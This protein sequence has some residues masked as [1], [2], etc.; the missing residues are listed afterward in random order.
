M[1]FKLLTPLEYYERIWKSTTK[2]IVI[3]VTNAW[4]SNAWV[5]DAWVSDA[6]VPKAIWPSITPV[7]LS[8]FFWLLIFFLVCKFL[9]PPPWV[10]SKR[11]SPKRV[12]QRI[13]TKAKGIAVTISWPMSGSVRF[14]KLYL[15]VIW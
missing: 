7:T 5:S 4:V 1:Y 2:S 6:W 12:S 3:W 8:L 14:A 13:T 15:F 9:P 10:A 11:V